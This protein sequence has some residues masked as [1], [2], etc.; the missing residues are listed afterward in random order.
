M[1]TACTSREIGLNSSR[2]HLSEVGKYESGLYVIQHTACVFAFQML[3]QLKDLRAFARL[4]CGAVIKIC[5]VI[6]VGYSAKCYE[7]RYMVFRAYVAKST[8]YKESRTTSQ[9]HQSLPDYSRG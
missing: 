8:S 2:H 6:S 5:S 3:Y 4:L 7:T 1:Q 9:H